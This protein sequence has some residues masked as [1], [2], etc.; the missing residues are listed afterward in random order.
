MGKWNGSNGMEGVE[1]IFGEWRQ[2]LEKR[3]LRVNLEKTNMMV[4]GRETENIILVE[5]YSC[6]CVV[7]VLGLTLFSVK[8]VGN[9]VI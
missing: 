5:R 6:D 9:C 4:T 1:L 8:H 2:V 7:V 3:R